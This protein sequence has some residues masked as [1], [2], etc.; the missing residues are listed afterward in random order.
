MSVNQVIK[1]VVSAGVTAV[2]IRIHL[3]TLPYLLRLRQTKQVWDSL[4]TRYNYLS[5]SHAQELRTQLSNH[6]KVS[7]IEVYIDK[8]K[9]ISQKLA[10]TGSLVADDELVFHT[11]RGLP[12]LFN[13][14]K[15]AVR[16]F[17]ARGTKLSFDEIVALLNSEDDQ[18]LQNSGTDLDK[19]T[20]LVT[21][22][23]NPSSQQSGQS[24][25]GNVGGQSTDGNVGH[26]QY[27]FGQ[28]MPSFNNFYPQLQ[29]FSGNFKNGPRGRGG[30]G[31][32]YPKEPC[33]ICGKTN[34]VTAYCYYRPTYSG[35][36]M[37]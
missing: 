5:D 19:S 2:K 12:P 34:H 15:T 6:T 22:Q 7:T 27:G 13:G 4:S 29:Q 10:A 1:K 32:R 14:L 30:K 8:I 33:T 25:G 20:V 16:A 35:M 31:S 17:S 23:S 37:P 28:P 3:S 24:T 21:T 18:L 26:I 11:L 36:S 9:E